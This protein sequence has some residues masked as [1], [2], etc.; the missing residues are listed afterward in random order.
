[1]INNEYE[2]YITKCNSNDGQEKWKIEYDPCPLKTKHEWIS[3]SER[4][5]EHNQMIHVKS[6]KLWIGEGIWQDG[7]FVYSFV[8]GACF[9]NP[10]HWKPISQKEDLTC[11]KIDREKALDE[12]TKI[13][14]EM[15]LYE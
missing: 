4:L 12:L 14:Q 15:G 2:Y 9:G 10:T 1:M 8:K 3:F 11:E 5:P 7:K 13:S 6:D